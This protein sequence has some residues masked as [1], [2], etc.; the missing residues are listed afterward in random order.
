MIK[1]CTSDIRLIT[2]KWLTVKYS[3]QKSTAEDYQAFFVPKEISAF[4]WTME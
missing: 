3:L 2:N 1:T 4:Q